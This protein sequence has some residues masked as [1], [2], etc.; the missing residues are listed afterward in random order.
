MAA[1]SLL[2]GVWLQG[3]NLHNST[4]SREYGPVPLASVLGRVIFRVWPEEEA[5]PIGQQPP[6]GITGAKPAAPTAQPWC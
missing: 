4:D 3:D 6:D 1:I 2:T 5:G